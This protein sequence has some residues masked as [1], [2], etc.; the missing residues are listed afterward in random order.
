MIPSWGLILQACSTLLLPSA[1]C[2]WYTPSRILKPAASAL[3]CYRAEAAPWHMCLSG[4]GDQRNITGSHS[5]SPVPSPCHS[6]TCHLRVRWSEVSMVGGS[7]EEDFC[8]LC[9]RLAKMALAAWSAFSVLAS[10]SCSYSGYSQSCNGKEG[11]ENTGWCF[12][13]AA[14]VLYPSHQSSILLERAAFSLSSCLSLVLY[15]GALTVLIYVHLFP[16]DR[17]KLLVWS[18]FS[19]VVLWKMPVH[20]CFFRHQDSL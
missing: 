14:A 8:Y 17:V 2:S 11:I 10:C 16:K 12:L 4:A 5:I 18:W 6:G 1:V 9:T 19:V 13:S 20:V 15:Q 7:G 3:G